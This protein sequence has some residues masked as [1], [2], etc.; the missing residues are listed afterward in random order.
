MFNP[1][2]IIRPKSILTVK[3]SFMYIP[4]EFCSPVK[5]ILQIVEFDCGCLDRGIVLKRC[6][7]NNSIGLQRLN[8][9]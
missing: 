3:I 5:Y 7:V 6:I 2:S 1:W 9:L 4:S 8:R